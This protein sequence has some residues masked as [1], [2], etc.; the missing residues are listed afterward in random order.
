MN[1]LSAGGAISKS[2]TSRSDSYGKASTVYANI[3]LS[4]ETPAT[5][6]LNCARANHMAGACGQKSGSLK[7]KR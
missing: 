5:S 4:E 1:G 2:C 3:S 7:L 6:I